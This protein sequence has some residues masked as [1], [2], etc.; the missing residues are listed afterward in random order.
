MEV[1]LEKTTPTDALLK[2]K[3]VRED[4]QP[5]IDKTLKEYSKKMQLKGFRPGKVPTQVVQ[6]M[7]GKGILMDEINALLSSTVSDYIRD[8]KL[9]VVGDPLID[10]QKTAEINWNNKEFDFEYQLGL[11]SDFEVN[12][13]AL[14]AVSVYDIV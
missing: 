12:L 9:P 13:G 14:P 5:K 8:N 10:R 4:Y 7:Y 6:K 2:I 11:A 3:L 1:L